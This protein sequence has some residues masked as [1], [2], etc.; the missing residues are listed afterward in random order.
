MNFLLITIFLVNTNVPCML[1][2]KSP[3]KSKPKP[4]PKIE[5]V[6]TAPGILNPFSPEWYVP[7][8]VIVKT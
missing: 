8:N 5:P 4:A 7:R 1:C 3:A 6:E 2:E